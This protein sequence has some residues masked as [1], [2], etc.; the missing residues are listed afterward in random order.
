MI[1]IETFT[2]IDALTP[3]VKVDTIFNKVYL[4]DTIFN[5]V[6]V[7]DTMF[8]K[9]F[10]SDTIKPEL[11]QIYDQLI[12]N[13]DNNFDNI[14]ILITII[15]SVLIILVTL[16]NI[17]VAKELFKKDAKGIYDTQNK[18]YEVKL[19]E[20]FE[21]VEKIIDENVLQAISI[22]FIL[23]YL[24]DNVKKSIITLMTNKN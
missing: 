11:I 16:I 6:Y 22:S 14:L 12:S 4:S 20:K 2:K 7:S 10:V 23:D 24:A 8:N 13:Q 21:R 3:T 9:V 18:E 5:K 17:F 15:V 1:N 19:D